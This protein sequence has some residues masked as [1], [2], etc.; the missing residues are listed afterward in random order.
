[1]KRVRPAVAS[2]LAI[3][4]CGVGALAQGP[5]ATKHTDPPPPELADPIEAL[6]A[7]GGP[8]VT[9]GQK[10][11]DFWFVKSLP[12]RSG[13]SDASWSSVDE[14]TLVGAVRLSAAHTEIRGKTLKAG[15]YTLRFALQPQDGAHLGASPNREFLLLGPSDE[16]NSVGALGH[17]AAVGLSKKAIG[18]SH[19][20][21]W[22]IDP[23]QASGAAG[24]I[25]KNDIGLTS[26][27]V[28]VP[29]SRDGKDAGTIKFGIV[30]QGTIQP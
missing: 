17:D 30:V 11:I 15:L 19:P 2:L 29:V 25:V 9:V 26:V 27:V 18:T 12:L 6:L 23:P 4:L 1:M 7:P 22:S 24:A 5:V 10:T 16:D 8:R 28:E 14:G 21:S 3:A 20:A 13:T